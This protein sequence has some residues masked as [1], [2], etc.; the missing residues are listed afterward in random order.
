MGF[1]REAGYLNIT[2]MPS[3]RHKART[4]A[5]GWRPVRLPTEVQ[6]ADYDA[7]TI[8]D[9]E[10]EGYEEDEEGDKEQAGE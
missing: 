6:L 3:H 2:L 8:S 9:H 7:A 5:R 4:Q 10:E 1:A